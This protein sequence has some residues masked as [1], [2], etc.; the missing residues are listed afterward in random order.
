M[1]SAAAGTAPRGS[2]FQTRLNQTR[3]LITIA[4]RGKAHMADCKTCGKP[5]RPLG[6]DAASIYCDDCLARMLELAS[7][8]E[9]AKWSFWDDLPASPS[10]TKGPFTAV[11]ILLAI[12]SLV[13]V[14]MVASGVSWFNPGPGEMLRWGASYGP[15]TLTGQFWRVLTSMFLHYGIIHLLGNIYVLWRFG[16]PFERLFGR[17][18]TFAVYLLTGAAAVLSGTQWYPQ[19]VV[20]GAS[21]AIF[22]FLGVLI[23]FFSFG[24]IELPRKRKRIMLLWA[25]LWVLVF[26]F[27]GSIWLLVWHV[28][29]LGGLV[30]GLLLGTFLAFT[31]RSSG[32]A[33]PSRQSWILLA[34]AIVLAAFFFTLIATKPDIVELGRGSAALTK[35]DYSAAIPHLQR[36]LAVHPDA[37][38]FALLGNAFDQD[39]QIDDARK[40]YEQSVALDGGK[41]LV[42]IRLAVLCLSQG[43]PTKADE[44]LLKS[45]ELLGSEAMFF[46]SQNDRLTRSEEFEEAASLLRRAAEIA[47]HDK[48]A[49][50]TLA[51]IYQQQSK[52]EMAAKELQLAQD[53]SATR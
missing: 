49:H 6:T 13:W 52:F 12:N 23:A 34:T 45:A 16:L 31:F 39:R 38:V 5:S 25:L 17:W 51:Q 50:Q 10:A 2:L 41:P 30:C 26:F 15:M 53:T 33:R 18:V 37:D 35:A 7:Q 14:A 46:E 36:Y 28:A 27:W 47:P 1:D 21:G 29:H 4:D 19:A 48:V 42:R 3:V 40:A 43:Q 11:N 9:S 24:R 8:K 20:A 44:L 22:G 32:E